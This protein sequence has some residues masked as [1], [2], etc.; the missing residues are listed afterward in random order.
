MKRY[1]LFAGAH[2]YPSGGWRDL[3]GDFDSLKTAISHGTELYQ[4]WEG[5]APE[6]KY[7]WYHVIDSETM[8]EVA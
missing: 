3:I 6:R 1:L 2:Y 8:N 5:M 4:P 7:D